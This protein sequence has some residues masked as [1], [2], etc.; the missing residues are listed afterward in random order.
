MKTQSRSKSVRT[1]CRLVIGATL[2]LGAIVFAAAPANAREGMHGGGSGHVQGHV[3]H[4]G[5]H[6]AGAHVG[7]W[8][9]GGLHGAW[10]GGGG[11]WVHGWHGGVYGW[12]WFN[13]GLWWPYYGWGYPYYPY[14]DYP[15][16]YYPYPPPGDPAATYGGTPPPEQT[17][18][19]CDAA[20]GYYPQVPSCPGGWRPVPAAPSGPAAGAPQGPPP[21]PPPAQ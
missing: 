13:A 17:W 18:Y 8:H 14:Y 7:A 16:P 4:A 2:A 10:R 12:W 20:R 3:A 6:F 5:G 19:Y 11:R 1:R 21:G 9:G 15:Y